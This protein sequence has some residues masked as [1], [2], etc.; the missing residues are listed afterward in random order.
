MDW[1]GLIS[2]LAG[3]VIG[4][5]FVIV[6]NELAKRRRQKSA[7]EQLQQHEQ[8]VYTAIFAIR[9]FIAEELDRL[10]DGSD[11]ELD[12]GALVSAQQHLHRLIEKSQPDSQ[13][14]LITIFEVSLRLDDLL[15]EFEVVSPEDRPDP[16]TA[17]RKLEALVSAIDHFD[18][19]SGSVLDFLDDEDI[20]EIINKNS[21]QRKKTEI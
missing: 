11:H 15:S 2:Q 19:V 5:V 16:E 3:V 1:Y 17:Q 7:A 18:I 9:N 14:L 6:A 10:G 13:T 12:L 20:D 4:G 8:A 21:Y